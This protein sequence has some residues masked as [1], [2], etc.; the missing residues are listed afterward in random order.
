LISF[1]FHLVSIVA[2][3]LALGLG[4]L[5]GTTV[6]KQ[7]VIDRLTVQSNNAVKTAG[8]LRK[9]VSQLQGQLG[10][11]NAFIRAVEPQLVKDQL[12][13]TPVIV[14]TLDGVDRSEVDGVR[15]TL[16]DSGASLVAI[17]VATPKMALTNPG[18]RTDLAE[19][20]GTT[21][22]APLARLSAQAGNEIG[23]RLADGP[24]TDGSPDLVKELL[25]AGFLA[26]AGGTSTD[27]VQIGGPNQSIVLL[28]GNATAT[29]SIHPAQF[30][31]PVTE[32]VLEADPARPV[33]A[34]ETTVVTVP[35]LTSIRGNRTLDGH[36]VTIDNADTMPGQVGVVLGLHDLQLSPGDGGDYGVNCGSCSLIP[37]PAP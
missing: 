5:M 20:L 8:G 1:R 27:A 22:A 33:V 31:T 10:S 35:F 17:L 34:A 16:S 12:T 3:F 2:V 30:L 37:N 28:S 6:V 19:I 36:L 18:A 13:G 15:K 14:V 24:G 32:A 23:K 9:Q 26:L 29:P 11:Q 7:S 4:V 25:A 21:D